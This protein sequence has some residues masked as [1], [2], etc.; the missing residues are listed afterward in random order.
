M[1]GALPPIQPNL[2]FES[3]L[4]FENGFE[5]SPKYLVRE[6]LPVILGRVIWYHF[7]EWQCAQ[8]PRW[9]AKGK[10]A[11]SPQACRTTPPPGRAPH[12]YIVPQ[13]QTVYTLYKH[14]SAPPTRQCQ[15][16]QLVKG[17]STQGVKGCCEDKEISTLLRCTTGE[18]F[19][20]CCG[21]VA[22]HFKHAATN[23]P[24]APQA[25]A[26]C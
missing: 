4:I 26:S 9:A 1:R 19:F 16:S 10:C 11:P 24:I 22:D 15:R 3:I 12:R 7:C 20:S 21:S 23:K 13:P 18:L 5:S 6:F 8:S 17:K 25:Q 2:F 14:A